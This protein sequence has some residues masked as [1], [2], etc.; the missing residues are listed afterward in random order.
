MDRNLLTQV[1]QSVVSKYGQSVKVQFIYQLDSLNMPVSDYPSHYTIANINGTTL[2]HTTVFTG[3]KFENGKPKKG[4]VGVYKNGNIIWDSDTTINCRD[5][6]GLSVFSI[7]D[8]NRDGKIDLIFAADEFTQSS[9]GVERL[10]IYLWNGTGGQLIT[11]LDSQGISTIV[12][13]TGIGDFDFVDV[14]GDGVYEIIGDWYVPPDDLDEKQVTYYWNGIDYVFNLALPQPQ[15]S[16]FL[17]QDKV[18]I[19]L[20]AKVSKSDS[21]FIYKYWIHNLPTSTQE[22]YLID[23]QLKIDS[24]SAKFPPPGWNSIEFF[25]LTGFE[26]LEYPTTNLDNHFIRI[27]SSDS[28]VFRSFYLPS[29]VNSYFQGYNRTPYYSDSMLT[30]QDFTT[31]SCLTPEKIIR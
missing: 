11:E 15:E 24:L 6:D 25:D 16:D 26:D 22:I 29:I 31:I 20:N 14:N 10:Y 2:S 30:W 21:G 3:F 9:N 7:A 4:I 28:C 1:N 12:S 23:F 13:L 19:V 18:N 5:I 17:V 27:D 8:I